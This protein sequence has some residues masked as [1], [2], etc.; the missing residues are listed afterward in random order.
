MAA[1][2]RKELFSVKKFRFVA[3]LLISIMLCS[4]ISA[5][6]ASI[7]IDSALAGSGVVKVSCADTCKKTKVMV[8]KGTTK[9]YY[10]LKNPE[11]SFPLQMGDGTYTVSVLENISGTSYKVLTKKSFKA[12]IAEENSLYLSSVQPVTWN[13]DM[14][15]IKL[16]KHITK[17]IENDN[18]IVKVL[19]DYTIKNISYDYG[20]ADKPPEDYIPEIDKVLEDGKGIC[21]DYSVLFAAML[22]SEGVPAKLVKGYR[23]GMNVY[24]AWNEV[25]LD[26]SWKVIDTTYSA[27]AFK[28]GTS[29]KM[30]QD[31][32]LYQKSKEY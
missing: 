16:A 14:E 5:Y 7:S 29:S 4:P 25:Y 15:A 22:R 8:E 27:C 3:I 9:Y 31:N 6:A 13:E 21:Y 28:A 18:E 20:K 17:G 12:E 19:Y 23:S 2:Y 26:G 11:D 10:D 30:I 1:S 24:H 32:N